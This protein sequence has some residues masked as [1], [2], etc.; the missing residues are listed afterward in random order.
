MVLSRQ[1][2]T[3]TILLAE[4][5]KD[6]YCHYTSIIVQWCKNL[7]FDD[8]FN[9]L[10]T[11]SL[12]SISVSLLTISFGDPNRGGATEGKGQSAPLTA[13][14]LP[15]IGKKRDEISKNR[16]REGKNREK[17]EKSGS[18]FHFAPPDR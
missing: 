14:N 13:K 10:K 11:K 5:L 9:A 15:K 6:H 12:K 3:L 4:K 17:E 18:F 8:F 16:E 7:I 2:L 1:F